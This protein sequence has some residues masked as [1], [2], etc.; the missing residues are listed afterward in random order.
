MMIDKLRHESIPGSVFSR[1][2]AIGYV[3]I[4]DASLLLIKREN[5]HYN[6]NTI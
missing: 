2:C 3:A 4:H 5:I 6:F 1:F